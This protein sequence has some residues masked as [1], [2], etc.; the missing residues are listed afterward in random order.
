MAIGK[1]IGAVTIL[2]GTA[3]IGYYFLEKNKP[4]IAEEQ[5]TQL[6]S[7]IKSTAN[8]VYTQAEKTPLELFQIRYAKMTPLERAKLSE[9]DLVRFGL[10]N[11]KLDTKSSTDTKTLLS[12]YNNTFEGQRQR[13][14]IEFPLPEAK[15]DAYGLNDCKALDVTLRNIILKSDEEA[16]KI[17]NGNGNQNF[18]NAMKERELVIRNAFV[19]NQCAVQFGNARLD[20]SGNV[21]TQGAIKAEKSILGISTTDENIYLKVGGLVLLVGLFVMLK[22]S[23]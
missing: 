8:A 5:L 3:L 6:Q 14:K 7:E 9:E 20:E 17:L 13:V 21:M 10:S 15:I 4:T 18:F 23:N 12:T 22:S 2:G 19:T 11:L 16:Q 1:V